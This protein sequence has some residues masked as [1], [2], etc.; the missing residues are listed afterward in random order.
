[1]H[2]ILINFQ[3]NFSLCA[4]SFV[5]VL[6]FFHFVSVEDFQNI[7]SLKITSPLGDAIL[8]ETEDLCLIDVGKY[9]LNII[10][11]FFLKY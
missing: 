6:L 5:H 7:L 11:V 9:P 2:V 4:T 1:M 10:D 3:A 8:L